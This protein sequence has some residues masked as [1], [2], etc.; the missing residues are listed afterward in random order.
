MATRSEE[1]RARWADAEIDGP[2]RAETVTG[3]DGEAYASVV[4]GS[5][6]AS[7]H[8]C[9]TGALGVP[10]VES[11]AERFAQAPGDIAYLLHREAE[12]G[13]ILGDALASYALTPDLMHNAVC[14]TLAATGVIG[15]RAAA[16]A[17]DIVAQ[18]YPVPAV[19]Q[20]LAASEVAHA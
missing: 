5:P 3:D 4:T 17:A 9:T 15:E 13:R 16:I 8:V 7:D 6:L 11:A 14:Y 18:L 19:A 12:A 1:I 10:G 20:P 2:W